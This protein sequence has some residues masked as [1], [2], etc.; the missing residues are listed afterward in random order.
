M[1]TIDIKF[2]CAFCIHSSMTKIGFYFCH[3]LYRHV[4]NSA[5]YSNNCN[6]VYY[7]EDWVKMIKNGGKDN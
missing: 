5:T 2:K 4:Y 1:D 7:K 3:K 6:G